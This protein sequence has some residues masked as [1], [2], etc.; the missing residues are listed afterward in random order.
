V[1]QKEI[2]ENSVDKGSA[3]KLYLDLFPVA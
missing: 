1:R 3:Q 2:S